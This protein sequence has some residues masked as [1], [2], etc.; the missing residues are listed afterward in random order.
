[1]NT[2][3]YLNIMPMNSFHILIQN[4]IQ[5]NFHKQRMF[6]IQNPI[7]CTKK[8]EYQNRI[9]CKFTVSISLIWK[10]KLHALQTPF[11]LLSVSFCPR[12]L[13]RYALRKYT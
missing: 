10:N 6:L 2:F 13:S 4:I 12:A 9:S 11:Y 5:S 3:Y 1:M 8:H 7:P